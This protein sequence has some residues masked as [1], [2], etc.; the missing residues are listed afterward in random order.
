MPS[1]A[2]NG[3]YRGGV[4]VD[5]IWLRSVCS[6]WFGGIDVY[7]GGIY[8][9]FSGCCPAGTAFTVVVWVIIF[10]LFN[11]SPAEHNNTTMTHDFGYR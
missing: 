10:F 2:H 8:I 11:F 7:R 4:G 9:P 1:G 5:S 3:V 6:V